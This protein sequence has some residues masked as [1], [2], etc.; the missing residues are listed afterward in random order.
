MILREEKM[1]SHNNLQLF[2]S[3]TSLETFT[4]RFRN[5]WLLSILFLL[6]ASGQKLFSNSFSIDT[7]GAISNQAAQYSAWYELNRFGLIWLKRVLRLYWYNNAVASF[8]CV[9]LLPLVALLWGYLFYG[10]TRHR[11]S[12]HLSFWAIPLMVSPVL[13]EQLGF[14]L[15]APEINLGLILVS[16]SLMILMNVAYNL[17]YANIRSHIALIIVWTVLSIIIFTLT[18]SMYTAF[19]TIF[20]SAVGMVYVLRFMGTS[21]EERS[22][23]KSFSAY[24]CFPAA[25]TIISYILYSLI[26][27]VVLLIL[28][29]TTNSYITDQL[30]WGKDS[31][32]HILTAIALHAKKMILANRIYYFIIFTVIAVIMFAIML[33]KTFMR[34]NSWDVTLIFMAVLASPLL[35]SVL[36]GS[37]STVRTEFT[38]TWAASFI[39]MLFAQSLSSIKI[40]NAKIMLGKIAAWTLVLCIGWCQGLVTNRIFYTESVVYSQDIARAHQIAQQ[41]SALGLGETPQEPVVFVGSLPQLGN[42]DTYSADKLDLVGRSLFSITFST[43]HGTWVKNHFFS[44]QGYTYKMPNTQQMNFADMETASMPQWPA[45]DSIKVEKGVIIVNLQH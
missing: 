33:V 8:L 35:M 9:A 21:R 34:K 41:I 43:Q 31:L 2:Y 10:V 42:S 23:N 15:Q 44:A 6:L 25:V 16:L 37:A 22:R 11:E 40:H 3:W 24:I 45:A 32:P 27:K 26:N 17:S 39:V 20:I 12:F 18:L 4:H 28:H 36:L 14:L 29:K 38:Y 19:L 13:A 1:Q 7:E 5:E 30:R